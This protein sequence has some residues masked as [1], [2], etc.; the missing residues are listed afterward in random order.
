MKRKLYKVNTLGGQ[1]I[2]PQEPEKVVINLTPEILSD[3]ERWG[4]AWD[5]HAN[6]YRTIESAA[7]AINWEM[8]N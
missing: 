3:L 6:Y 7:H 5:D 8:C 2:D 1:I 4:F